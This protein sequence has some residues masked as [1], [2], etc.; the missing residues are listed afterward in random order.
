MGHVA[1]VAVFHKSADAAAWREWTFARFDR[2]PAVGEYL[3]LWRSGSDHWYRVDAV[4]LPELRGSS[5]APHEPPPR[6]YVT[7][8]GEG[9]ALAHAA[10]RSAP[11]AGA[12]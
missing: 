1:V 5:D 3:E 8:V 9:E 12:G 6:V 7:A 4:V 10:A 11:I 2:L